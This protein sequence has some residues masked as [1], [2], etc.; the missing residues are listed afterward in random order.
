MDILAQW[1]RSQSDTVGM[2]LCEHV[3]GDMW[4]L[5]YR[6]LGCS[7][8]TPLSVLL[9]ART[10]IR[11]QQNNSRTWHTTSIQAFDVGYIHEGIHKHLLS[12][13]ALVANAYRRW[14]GVLVL[15]DVLVAT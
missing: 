13:I 4:D 12:C 10:D 9:G 7:L 5:I 6:T 2:R 1:D 15:G 8:D 11:P 14:T 3:C